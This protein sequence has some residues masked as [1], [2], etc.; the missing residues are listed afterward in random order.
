MS[1]ARTRSEPSRGAKARRIPHVVIRASAGSG[2]TFQLS[3]R[4][5][6]LLYQGVPPERIL[7][8]TFTRKAAGEIFDRIVLRLAEAA[9]D[10]KK[11]LELAEYIEAPELTTERCR[12]LLRSVT[13]SLD[14]LRIGTLDSFFAKI[15]GSC[16][17]ELGLPIGWTIVEEHVDARLRDR[18]IADSL[19]GE[20]TRPVLTLLNLLTK[21]EA[22]RSISRLIRDTVDEL[23]STI[24]ETEEAAWKQV[25]RPKGLAGEE[26]AEVF[27]RLRSLSYPDKNFTKAI[28]KD[29][30]YVDSGDWA[31]FITK[32]LASKVL[33]GETTYYR[34]PIGDEA[35]AIYDS[36]IRHAKYELVNIV[37]SQ[38][39][40]T[41]ELLTHFEQHY[42]RLKLAQA[43]L[44]FDDITHSL[45]SCSVS[46]DERVTFRLD[47]PI[48]HLLLDEFQDTSLS[49]WLVLRPIAQRVTGVLKATGGRGKKAASETSFFCVGDVKQAIYG[50]RG[51]LAELFDTVEKEL[52]GLEPKPLDTSYRSSQAVIDVVNR[53]FTRL[54]SHTNLEKYLPAVRKWQ[55]RFNPHSTQ[56][57]ELAGYVTLETGPRCDE[58][59]P[60]A[61]VSDALNDYV[62]TRVADAYRRYPGMTIGVLT[63]TNGAVGQLI[64]RLRNLGIPASEEGGN[65]LTDSA[66]VELMLSLVRLADHPSDTA[67]AYHVARSPL[68]THFGLS[69]E[70]YCQTALLA[71]QLRRELID[72][73]YGRALYRWCQLA[74]ECCDERDRSRLQQ[75]V[76]LAYAYQAQSSLRPS[77][78]L[79]YVEKQRVADPTTSMVRVMTVHQ[80]KGLEFDLVFL[81]E[82][83][84]SR[85]LV[86]QPPSLVSSRTGAGGR[87]DCVC[88]YTNDDVQKLLPEPFPKMFQAAI[89]AQ[90]SEA[91]CV[92]YVALT[93]AVHGLHIVIRPIKEKEKS[94]P[95]TFAGLIR[96]ALCE[97]SSDAG[98]ARE[99]MLFSHGDPDWYAQEQ[100]RRKAKPAVATPSVA[101]APAQ[102]TL[103]PHPTERRRGLQRESP[104]HLEGGA[105]GRVRRALELSDP[106]RDLAMLRGSVFHAWFELIQWSNEGIPTAEQLLA[107]FSVIRGV[108]IVAQKDREAWMHEF[109]DMLARG[110]TPLALDRDRYLSTLPKSWTKLLKGG[111]VQLRVKNEWPFAVIDRGQLLQ[112]RMDRVVFLHRDGEPVA[113]DVLDYKTDVVSDAPGQRIEER[114]EHYRPQVEAYCRTVVQ[115][116]GLP[117]SQ[118]TVGLLFVGPGVLWRPASPS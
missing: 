51:G 116:T 87:I 27:Q 93:R 71:E 29:I 107:A 89:D 63:R 95:K 43:S 52:P 8:V 20:A 49:Q 66:A 80:A 39:E 113:A 92:L 22:A 50:W 53:V 118:V 84:S 41:H 74:A 2:K 58:E 88:R 26:L 25:P 23:Y 61:D 31:S 14:R 42:G 9:S 60:A 5:L 19:S 99:G 54:D 37:A 40:A 81:P 11:R 76:E 28:E 78:F 35:L 90:V 47:A 111:D 70:N 64:Y 100:Q 91:L 112:G 13:R 48:D 73:G 12:E 114:V 44:R 34:K 46:D 7:A 1:N 83:D 117:A 98:A 65:P 97:S 75:L 85:T 82:F 68:G 109:H 72:A 115:Q 32:G 6:S 96:A 57:T 77:D 36:L 94:L 4:F 55:Q 38:T 33:V 17:M 105:A 102:I 56:R 18:A 67:A 24:R 45:A 10:D 104:S 16:S 79:E 59:D 62:A 3:N 21:G 69:A 110:D 86:S 15:A 103:A 101:A 108:E 106:R 30:A